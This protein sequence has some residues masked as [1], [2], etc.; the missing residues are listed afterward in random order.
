MRSDGPDGSGP[1]PVP[2]SA[3]A[4]ADLGAALHRARVARG[5]S[6]RGWARAL[7]MSG[8]SGLL[9]YERGQRTPPADLV[10]AS[11]RIFGVPAGE[12]M[13]MR[14]RVLAVR[15]DEAA[16]R[17]RA[18]RPG[19]PAPADHPPRP[20]QLPADLAT[21]TGREAELA[22]LLALVTDPGGPVATVG[23]VG[24]AGVGKTALAVHAAHRL[25]HRYPDGSLFVDLHGF[26]EAVAPVTPADALD[27]LLRAVG[28]T[29]RIPPT[30]DERAAAWRTHVAGRRMLIVV[31]NAAGE[32][33]VAPLLPGTRGCLVL[34]TSRRQLTGLDQVHPLPLDVL[35][36]PDS[37]TLFTRVAGTDRTSTSD[38]AV[39]ENVVELCGHLPLAI[40]I[41]AGR[42]RARPMWTPDHLAGLLGDQQQRLGELHAG[43]RSTAAA[44]RL[45][46]AN[47]TADQQRMFRLLGT[48]PGPDVDVP[49]AAALA[50]ATTDRARRCLED[51]LDAYLLRQPAL[52][53]Y[54]FHDLLRAFAAGTA[55]EVDPEPDRRAALTRMLDHYTGTAAA[56]TALLYP[57]ETTNHAPGTCFADS[58]QAAAWLDAELV[59]LLAAAEHAARHGWPRHA[60]DLSAILHRHLN[61]RGHHTRAEALHTHALAAAR[62]SGDRAGEQ[63]ALC[64][65][66]DALRRQDRPDAAIDQYEQALRI[67]RD[68]SERRGEL[69]ALVGLGRTHWRQSRHGPAAEYLG[70]ALEMARDTG[71]RT[72]EHEALTCLGYVHWQQG[73]Y[74]PAAECLG[75]ALD[76]A[77][78]TGNRAGELDALAG[79]GAT[80]RRQGRYDRAVECLE[81]AL[82]LARDV[83]D[84]MGEMDALGGLGNVHRTQGRY[85]PAARALEQVLDLA[86]RLG[87]RHHQLFSV[88]VLA[89]VRRAQGRHDLAARYYAQGLDIAREHADLNYQFEAVQGLGR[90]HHADGRPDS[91]VGFHRRALEL[92]EKLDQPADMA[93]AHD[94]L[95]HANRALG[96]DAEARE[97]WLRARDIL[98]AAGVEYTEDEQAN[99]AAIDAQLD[100]CP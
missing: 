79:L 16:A 1:D 63:A 74:E 39:L 83:G 7:G 8:H 90:L 31:D 34:V 56:A 88:I 42:L 77:R 91:A 60:V 71:H 32:A 17:L 66:G 54:G 95:G 3:G 73:R 45:S 80:Y 52:G 10:E 58:R 15:A 11:E 64:A 27:R 43:P 44:F 65:L 59:T 55:A 30:V 2:D 48:Q 46:Y 69:S 28:M 37:V 99:V 40:T 9:D 53:R 19:C 78:E 92:A 68:I 47:L 25:A 85:E 87:D 81:Q 93:R 13:A 18:Q 57:Y 33:Q 24:M 4:L 61:T 84:R 98:T 35:R 94:G 86:R 100:A 14:S 75:Q 12:L 23:I 22:A 76:I 97:H 67:A 96:Q 21:F 51:L 50:G 70:T 29:E 26:T 49:G 20:A 6:L 82:L 38:A 62:R 36:P 72:A 89:H 5:L 41:A